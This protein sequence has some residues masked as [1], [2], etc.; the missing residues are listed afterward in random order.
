MDIISGD[1]LDKSLFEYDNN[2]NVIYRKPSRFE[3]EIFYEFWY[4]YDK[5]GN[6]IYEKGKD[7]ERVQISTYEYKYDSNNKII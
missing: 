7:S 2:G 1:A 4:E 5:Y 3:D 6:V